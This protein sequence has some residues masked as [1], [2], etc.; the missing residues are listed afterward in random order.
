MGRYDLASSLIFADG[1]L[2]R[3][4]GI[5]LHSEAQS[6]SCTNKTDQKPDTNSRGMTII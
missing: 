6:V 4:E 3:R 1:Q 2:G 5:H